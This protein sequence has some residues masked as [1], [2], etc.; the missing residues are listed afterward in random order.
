MS[1]VI[2]YARLFADVCGLSYTAEVT[3]AFVLTFFRFTLYLTVYIFL[4]YTLY[5]ILQ[6]VANQVLRT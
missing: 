5:C 6:T 1:F 2:T 4:Q 3:N